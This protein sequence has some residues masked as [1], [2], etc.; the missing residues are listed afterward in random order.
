MTDTDKENG[1]DVEGA[2]W[3]VRLVEGAKQFPG[4]VWQITKGDPGA[5]LDGPDGI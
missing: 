2:P 4:R 1:K 3:W 5:L